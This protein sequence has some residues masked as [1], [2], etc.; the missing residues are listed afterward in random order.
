M[1]AS[2]DPVA[3]VVL[4]SALGRAERERDWAREVVGML[5]RNE[6]IRAEVIRERNAER[7]QL[8]EDLAAAQTARLATE[9]ERDGVREELARMAAENEDLRATLAMR[10]GQLLS[11]RTEIDHLRAEIR[12]ARALL[13]NPNENR[14]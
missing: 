10:T 5:R 12:E 2:G 4:Q 8:R 6:E 11:A 14:G 9:R 1:S 3:L 7:A 13:P